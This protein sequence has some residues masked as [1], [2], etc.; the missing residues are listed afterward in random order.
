MLSNSHPRKSAYDFMYRPSEVVFTQLRRCCQTSTGTTD[1]IQRRASV[2]VCKLHSRLIIICW[3][4]M[5]QINE[6]GN[7]TLLRSNQFSTTFAGKNAIWSLPSLLWYCKASRCWNSGSIDSFSF[8]KSKVFSRVALRIEKV[9]I[10]LHHQ[11][12]LL[13]LPLYVRLMG[14][15]Q[16]K[17]PPILPVQILTCCSLHPADDTSRTRPSSPTIN[18]QGHVHPNATEAPSTHNLCKTL[19]NPPLLK[20]CIS[21]WALTHRPIETFRCIALTSISISCIPVT[22][23][24]RLVRMWAILRPVQIV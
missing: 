24:P 11:Q 16:S 23:A 19:L 3:D 22:S 18:G 5:S 1:S 8:V 17:Q 20:P 14:Q 7:R 10:S 2:W 9:P 13:V 4:L 12:C 6:E 15:L 21:E